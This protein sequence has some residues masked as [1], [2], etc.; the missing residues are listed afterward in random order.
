MSGLSVF[1][2]SWSW[3]S[4]NGESMPRLQQPIAIYYEHPHWFLPLFAALD[5]ADVPFVRVNA[6]RHLFDPA[7]LNGESNYSLIFNRMSPSA[8]RPVAG[9]GDFPYS[10]S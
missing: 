9:P 7:Q 8:Y 1:G 4:E 6:A 3:T 5:K 10:Y 2:C